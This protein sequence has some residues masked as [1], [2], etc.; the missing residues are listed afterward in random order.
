MGSRTMPLTPPHG[1]PNARSAGVTQFPSA[2]SALNGGGTSGAQQQVSTTLGSTGGVYNYIPL[3]R[4]PVRALPRGYEAG[5]AVCRVF[6]TQQVARE[7]VGAAFSIT[8]GSHTHFFAVDTA[9][10]ADDWVRA[11]TTAWHH[12]AWHAQR[13]AHLGGEHLNEALEATQRRA[14]LEQLLLCQE[15]AR[16]EREMGNQLDAL[17]RQNE[18]LVAESR[19][20]ATYEV[21]VVT[22]GVRGGGTDSRAYVELSGTN[23]RS[24]GPQLLVWPPRAKKVFRAGATDVFSVMGPNFGALAAVRVGHDESGGLGDWH[25]QSVH[26]RKQCGAAPDGAPVW[27]ERIDFFADCWLSRTKG[28]VGLS[29]ELRAGQARGKV[30]QCAAPQCVTNT[31]CA[32]LSGAC[33]CTVPWSAMTCGLRSA[34]GEPAMSVQVRGGGAHERAARRW[35][36]RPPLSAPAAERSGCS[37]PR[38]WQRSGR[39]HA[40][41]T[42]RPARHCV[43]HWERRRCVA[44]ARRRRCAVAL[45]AALLGVLEALSLSTGALAGHPI[46]AAHSSSQNG[47]PSRRRHALARIFIYLHEVVVGAVGAMWHLCSSKVIVTCASEDHRRAR[48]DRVPT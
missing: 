9:R 10:E 12:C 33:T 29:A 14:Q 27:G 26:V 44:G 36:D 47:R 46:F 19:R 7:A 5:T 28:E 35:Y 38:S 3:D 6:D 18:E 4:I 45:R 23:G 8:A 43:W 1:S 42:R 31:T 39:L 37:G 22:S 48:S 30:T 15:A 20:I 34:A 11:I 41:Q 21:T 40:G 2:L 13:S 16:R 24:G 17:R 32:P 25:L